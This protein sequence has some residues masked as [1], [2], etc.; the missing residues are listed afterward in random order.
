MGAIF[1]R[2]LGA[3]FGII[4]PL[5]LWLIVAAPTAA[6]TWFYFDKTSAV[7]RAVDSF[8]RELVAGAEIASLKAQLD[9]ANVAAALQ[10]ARADTLQDVNKQFENERED[11]EA[12]NDRLEAKVAELLAKPLPE[13]CKPEDFTVKEEDLIR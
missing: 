4:I 7:R 12:E 13:T 11:D 9:A 10:K 3:I 5:P 2:W 1:W 8:G 6:Y